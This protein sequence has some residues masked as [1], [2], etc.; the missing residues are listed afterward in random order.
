MLRPRLF[1]TI[2]LERCRDRD[3]LR[4]RNLKDVE[5]ET[6]DK[7][8]VSTTFTQSR[9]VSVST[10]SKFLGLEESRSRHISKFMVS[11]SLGLDIFCFLS[12]AD[13][14][15]MYHIKKSKQDSQEKERM[16]K[17]E[18]HK[19]TTSNRK[20]QEVRKREKREV[21]EMKRKLGRLRQRKGHEGQG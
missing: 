13:S 1:E 10:S 9:L 14:I 6:L 11:K 17:E 15:S 12:L 5:S 2:N 20:W 7:V 8:S 21:R 18:K 16:S 4:P 19:A 3:F